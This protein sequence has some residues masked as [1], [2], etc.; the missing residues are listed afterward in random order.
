MEAA[1]AVREDVYFESDGVRCAA[2]LYRQ[3]ASGD[4]PCIVLAHGFGTVREGRLP[5][6]AE[7]FQ[8]A[9]FAALVF[10]YR[11]FGAS[12]GE[13]RQLIR[14]RRQHADWRAAVAF[15]RTLEGIDPER[16]A[17]WGTSYSGGHVITVAAGD[18][19]IAAVVA[20]TPHTSGPAT[21][22]ALGPAHSLRLTGAA[23]RDALSVTLGRG[24]RMVPLVGPPG[25]L[26]AM[27]S[28]EA[29]EGW[30]A[31]FPEGFEPVN[32]FSPRAA[33]G[34]P[35]YSPLRRARKVRCPLLVQLCTEDSITPAEPARK[36]AARAP[37]ARLREYPGDHF[38]IYVGENF[39]RAVADQV[40]FF[41]EHLT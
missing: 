6:Y 13:P 38:G 17:L 26:A 28:P 22:S 40:E 29:V 19:R 1:T 2:W 39:E 27:T 35:F 21:T 3:Q 16:V 36:L 23:L 10:D 5:A 32:E 24:T 34:M 14:I 12:G 9:G 18:P 25:S 37:R 15:A 20:Q 33:L 8:A 7:R 41:R 30:A 31:L 11:H 4:V